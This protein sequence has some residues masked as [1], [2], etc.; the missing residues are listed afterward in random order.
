[1][2]RFEAGACLGCPAWEAPCRGGSSGRTMRW[3]SCPGLTEAGASGSPRRCGSIVGPS[4]GRGVEVSGRV[5]VAWV[6]RPGVR[7]LSWSPDGDGLGESGRT[8]SPCLASTGTGTSSGPVWS[9]GMDRGCST[10]L[11]GCKIFACRISVGCRCPAAEVSEVDGVAAAVAGSAGCRGLA[12][13]GAGTVAVVLGE[14]RSSL[15]TFIAFPYCKAC[16]RG[17]DAG[18]IASFCREGSCRG[19]ARVGAPALEVLVVRGRPSTSW[20]CP[21][22]WDGLTAWDVSTDEKA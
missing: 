15:D 5:R 11:S 22:D 4:V 1:M 8:A 10:T 19:G 13:C 18:P 17:C 6:A 9:V 7:R 16:A 2:V 3:L 21:A 20:T 14:G 12:V